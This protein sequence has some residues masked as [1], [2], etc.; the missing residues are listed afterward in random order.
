MEMGR[1]KSGFLRSAKC[2]ILLQLAQCD[3]PTQTSG[4]SELAGNTIIIITESVPR[5]EGKIE[6]FDLLLSKS[7]SGPFYRQALGFS[8]TDRIIRR[9]SNFT[10]S[11]GRLLRMIPQEYY[12]QQFDR[13]LHDL[14]EDIWRDPVALDAILI[15]SGWTFVGNL[16][17]YKRS[18]GA[19]SVEV[20]FHDREPVKKKVVIMG[21]LKTQDNHWVAEGAYIKRGD[22]DLMRYG[23]GDIAADQTVIFASRK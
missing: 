6:E 16:P 1:I 3:K 4:G 14:V 15:D 7:S 2:C 10:D 20:V 11:W 8:I 13:H 5:P 22:I 23:Y 12:N 9:D 19:W 21:D 17:L 18:D